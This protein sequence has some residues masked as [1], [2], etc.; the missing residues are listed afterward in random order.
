MSKLTE[1]IGL[2]LRAARRAAKFKSAR[3]FAAQHNIPESTYSQHE[4]GKRALNPDMLLRYSELLDMNPGWL[5][6]GEG[7]PYFLPK[8]DPE[9]TADIYQK[10]VNLKNYINVSVVDIPIK[11]D[12]QIGIDMELFS[13][14]FREIT[15]SFAASNMSFT[16]KECVEF[17]AEVYNTVVATSIEQKNRKAV[18]NISIA[19]L[20]RGINKKA[21]N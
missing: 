15:R 17:C 6:T 1:Q 20:K 5:L 7:M 3:I 8:E 14:I 21:K 9:N 16:C 19:S 10:I 13:E 2:R 11:K 12:Q 18:I 4:T